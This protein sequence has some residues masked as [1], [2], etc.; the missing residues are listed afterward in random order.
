MTRSS[1]G[2]PYDRGTSGPGHAPFAPVAGSGAGS[3][4]G[5]V[6]LL[7]AEESSW[8][9]ALVLLDG[10]SNMVRGRDVFQ[11]LDDWDPSSIKAPI[12]N[13]YTV[14]NGARDLAILRSIQNSARYH[15]LFHHAGHFDFQN[16]P[17]Y[18]ALV[19]VPDRRG[20]SRRPAEEGS[21]VFLGVVA[22]TRAFLD[23]QLRAH[24]PS[25]DLV[26]GEREIRVG[27]GEIAEFF[28]DP[29]GRN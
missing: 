23:A 5:L 10:S 8:I 13:M 17:L 24:P 27:L 20:L 26:R 22:L 3:L 2:S 18:S 16:W 12:L 28:T 19:G 9:D 11:S 29:A 15:V 4:P 1:V 6:A 14:A 7:L 25:L 21:N